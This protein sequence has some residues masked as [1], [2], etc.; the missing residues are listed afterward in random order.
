MYMEV[1]CRKKSS[2]EARKSHY[3][4]LRKYLIKL[5]SS[6]CM[7]GKKYRYIPTRSYSAFNVF[8]ICKSYFVEKHEILAQITKN[9]RTPYIMLT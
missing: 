5:L 9:Q 6:N 3:Q 7:S 1:S 2:Q 8:K 4:S